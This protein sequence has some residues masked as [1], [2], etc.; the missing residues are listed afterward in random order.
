MLAT[1][2]L[3]V[4]LWLVPPHCITSIP[5]AKREMLVLWLRNSTGVLLDTV[6]SC[7][8]RPGAEC[9][10]ELN[11]IKVC[12]GFLVCGFV[13]QSSTPVAQVCGALEYLED[14]FGSSSATLHV[15]VLGANGM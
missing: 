9:P 12:F 8:V 1:V 13:L 10:K 15:I 5:E 3:I 4:G 11:Q 14:V 2:P 7:S 6:N